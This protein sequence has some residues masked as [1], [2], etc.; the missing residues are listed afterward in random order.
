MIQIQIHKLVHSYYEYI[1]ART[2]PGGGGIGAKP[3]LW[4][5]EK[6]G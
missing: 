4:I 3:P 5:S 1:K 2:L 6:Y